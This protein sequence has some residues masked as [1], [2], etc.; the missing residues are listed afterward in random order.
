ML[1]SRNPQQRCWSRG[2]LGCTQIRWV[3]G[4]LDRVRESPQDGKVPASLPPVG[5]GFLFRLCT[6]LLDGRLLMP[7]EW[8]ER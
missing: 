6:W 1:V 8:S 7:P 3:R 4:R 2:R 5:L